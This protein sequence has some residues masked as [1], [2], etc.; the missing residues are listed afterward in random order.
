MDYGHNKIE[1]NKNIRNQLSS[2]TT[3]NRLHN[4][5]KF[6]SEPEIRPWFTYLLTQN[7]TGFE[8]DCGLEVKMFR[9]KAGTML[10][11]KH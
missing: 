8:K 10:N 3:Q 2:H 5:F 6:K 4:E 1:V 7:T 9:W 11:H